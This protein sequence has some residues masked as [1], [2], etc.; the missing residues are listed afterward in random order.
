MMWRLSQTT[1]ARHVVEKE[2]E[3]LNIFER[4]NETSK[5]DKKHSKT[6]ENIGS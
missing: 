2:Q 4:L 6:Y 1:P 5:Y 3:L